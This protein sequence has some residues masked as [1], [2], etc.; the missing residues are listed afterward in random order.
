MQ[1][2]PKK[3]IGP[4]PLAQCVREI[5]DYLEVSKINPS[6]DMRRKITTR[7]TYIEVQ[8]S[9]GGIAGNDLPRYA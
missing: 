7:G 8:P 4:H 9:K 2:L 6:P 5:I 3:P 1:R